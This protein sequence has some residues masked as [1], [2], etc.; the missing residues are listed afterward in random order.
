MTMNFESGEIQSPKRHRLM[1]LVTGLSAVAVAG[2]FA[3]SA[4]PAG[5]VG[6]ATAVPTSGANHIIVGTG[7][8]TTYPMMNKLDILYNES[9]Q[10]TMTID[11]A[12]ASAIQPLDFS[13]LTATQETNGGVL[14]PINASTSTTTN[15]FGDVVVEEPPIGSSNGILQ[16][17]SASG[18]ATAINNKYSYATGALNVFNGASY[19]RSSRAASNAATGDN[20]GLNFVAYAKDGV[21][22]T[23]YVT[24]TASTTP[25]TYNIPKLT[26]SELAAIWKGN[27][28]NWA[29]VGG[30]NA[31][32][33]VF[34]AQTG[35][36]TQSTWKTTLGTDPSALPGSS[37][38]ANCYDTGNTLAAPAGGLVTATAATTQP[39]GAHCN[40]PINIFEN[41]VAQLNLAA[42]PANMTDPNLAG[43]LNAGAT[44]ASAS[45]PYTL[46][47]ATKPSKCYAWW[48]GCTSTGTGA[49]TVWTF[50]SQVNANVLARSIFFYSAGLFKQQC[51]A[52]GGANTAATCANNQYKVYSQD[53]TGATTLA[54]GGIG[55]FASG[56]LVTS[57][58]PSTGEPAVVCTTVAGDPTPCMPTQ[59]SILTGHFPSTRLVYNVYADNSQANQPAATAAALNY[60]GET[61]FLCTP[62]TANITNPQS[63]K[64]YLTEIQ[65]T[66]VASGFYPISAG[67]TTGVINQTAIPEGTFGV[68]QTGAETMYSTGAYAPFLAHA[69]G[70]TASPN[71]FC[72]F[73]T[74]SSSTPTPQPPA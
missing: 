14:N 51:L 32:I 10:C 53:A 20:K 49:A 42:L 48:L 45:A 22:W 4:V 39:S 26:V 35:S 56:S 25:C 40:G 67:A 27:L 66:I 41:E 19:A 44:H 60:V 69:A 11:R 18:S 2:S 46:T 50:G 61:G 1:R 31:P 36:G 73:S 21:T 16:L 24:T 72:L 52:A 68:G 37:F 71:G 7:S 64:S 57:N 47:G 29:Q 70:T 34:T 33:I 5:A 9:P 12:S 58:I 28:W 6:N 55:T 13:C 74:T 17:E 65:N 15:P 30:C 63:G 38:Y 59:I 54:L 8:S 62:R 3:I 43:G 23:H